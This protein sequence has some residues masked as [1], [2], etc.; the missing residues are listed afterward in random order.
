[1]KSN[2][3]APKTTHPVRYPLEALDRA[4]EFFAV[5][6]LPPLPR[7]RWISWPRYFLLCHTVEMGLKAFLAL[8]SVP[9]DKLER[10]DLGHKIDRLMKRAAKEGLNIG[11]AAIELIK[12]G[13]AHTNHWARYPHDIGKAVFAIEHFEPYVEELLKVVSEAVRGHD[14]D[15]ALA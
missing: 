7:G 1:M 13:E 12:L 10:Q 11:S 2:P 5:R 6:Q 9:T 3:G 4:D 15:P 14:P 8:R